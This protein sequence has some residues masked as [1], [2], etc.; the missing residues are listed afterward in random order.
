MIELVIEAMV[1]AVVVVDADGHIT[2][3]NAGAEELSGFTRE[4]LRGMPIGKLL[5]DDSSGLRTLVRRRIAGG[6]VLRREDSRMV[7]ANGEQIEVSVTGSPVLDDKGALQGIVLVARDTREL[8]HVLADREAEIAR[9]RAAE[10]ELRVAK[11]SIEQQL[12]E[13]RRMLMLAERRATLGTLAGGVG[14]E[15]RNIAQIQ[16]A[17]IDELASTLD[18][19]EDIAELARQLLPELQRVAEHITLHGQKLMQLARP[20]PD[21]V[22]PIDLHEV[23]RDVASMLRLAGKLGRVDLE[24]ELGSGPLYVTVNRARLEQILVNLV[25]NA[26]DA[27]GEMAAGTIT[28]TVKPSSDERHVACVVRDT[29]TGITPDLLERIFEPFFTTKGPDKGTGLGL[30]VVRDIVTSYGGT[31]TVESEPGQGTAFTFELPR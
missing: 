9:R 18:A 17:A 5:V 16:V 27:I 19:D 12:A 23:V 15:L 21:H 31:L 24:L 26:V 22:A 6:D 20:G 2:M 3:A 8:R 28:I 13:A 7:T 14:H 29:G 11:E 1:D 10:D 30:P 4:Q 25:I